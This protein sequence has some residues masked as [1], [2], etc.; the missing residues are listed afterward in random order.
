VRPPGRRRRTRKTLATGA[1]LWGATAYHPLGSTARAT[2]YSEPR[3]PMT[4]PS[5]ILVGARPKRIAR[6]LKSGLLVPARIREDPAS[7]AASVEMF[8]LALGLSQA[9]GN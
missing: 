6:D 7:Q 8:P 2:T 4:A 5:K 3:M 1:V 9:I